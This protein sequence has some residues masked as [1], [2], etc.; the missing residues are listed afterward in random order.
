MLY[1][2]LPEVLL[3]LLLS[4]SLLLLHHSATAGFR[5]LNAVKHLKDRH[6]FACLGVCGV[7]GPVITPPPGVRTTLLLPPHAL[8]P[9]FAFAPVLVLV[10][11]LKLVFR[12]KL[13]LRGGT[14]ADAGIRGGAGV[15]RNW[16]WDWDWDSD[17]SDRVTVCE[18][19]DVGGGGRGGANV[20]DVDIGVASGVESLS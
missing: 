12:L 10:P 17:R 19:G 9:V 8:V 20:L 15:D 18:R 5:A 6:K 13:R 16:D 14:G 1:P 3:L 7:L 2:C 4:L 11:L